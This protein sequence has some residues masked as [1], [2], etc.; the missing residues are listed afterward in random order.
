MFSS[1][2][3][4]DSDE[5]SPRRNHQAQVVFFA[6]EM[7]VFEIRKSFLLT[8]H[9]FGEI[10]RY[11][12]AQK[13][14]EMHFIMR[15]NNKGDKQ[16]KD[17]IALNASQPFLDGGIPLGPASLEKYERLIHELAEKTGEAVKSQNKDK[18]LAFLHLP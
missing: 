15:K 6:A 7:S 2:E 17:L 9:K 8:P 4:S 18:E 10:V 11:T 1:T 3:V 13:R 16:I 5:V 14:S 12:A